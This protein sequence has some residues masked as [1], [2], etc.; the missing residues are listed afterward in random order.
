MLLVR[1]GNGNNVI[2]TN[3]GESEFP[4]DAAAETNNAVMAEIGRVA[5]LYAGSRDESGLLYAYF[6]R[7]GQAIA[8]RR[9]GRADPPGAWVFL[10]VD[11]NGVVVAQEGYE[12]LA[13]ASK[14]FMERVVDLAKDFLVEPVPLSP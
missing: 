14:R 7:S 2:L 10:D 13:Q 1:L 11:A 9:S 4:A 6:E 12:D 8:A 5:E 3:E